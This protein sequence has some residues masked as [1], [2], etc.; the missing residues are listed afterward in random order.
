MVCHGDARD[1][2]D[3]VMSGERAVLTDIGRAQVHQFVEQVRTRRVAGVYCP[4]MGPAVQSADLAASELGLRAVVVE[5]LQDSSAGDL[6]EVNSQG[7][8]RFTQ[9]IGEIADVHRGETVL[10]FTN[11]AAISAVIAG[12]WVNVGNDLAGQ[13]F[14]PGCAV[15]EVEVDADGWRLVSWPGGRDSEQA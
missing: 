2:V 1:G 15:A 10:V 14:L 11:G 9:A 12:V 5:G 13:G 3:D 4:R 8:R 7:Q 6:A